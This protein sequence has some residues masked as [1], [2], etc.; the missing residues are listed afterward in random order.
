MV[1]QRHGS[2]I[3]NWVTKAPDRVAKLPNS[4]VAYLST[5]ARARCDEVIG[6]EAAP[7]LKIS[8]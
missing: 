2:K 7:R 6:S 4:I 5:S 3:S 8:N 1:R